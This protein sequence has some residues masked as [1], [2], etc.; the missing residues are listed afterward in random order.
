MLERYP[1]FRE[2]MEKSFDPFEVAMRLALAG[3]VI[4]FGSKYQLDAL[5]ALNN[6]S[7]AKLAV[8]DSKHLRHDLK[9]ATTLLYIGDNCGEIVLDRLFL[10]NINLP[11]MYYAVR[12]GPIINDVT[13]DD[14]EMVGMNRIAKVTS[15]GDDAPGVVW[16]ST[17]KEFKQIFSQADVIIAKGQGNL[18]GLIDIPKNIYFLLVTKCELIGERLGT[19]PDGFVV[20]RGLSIQRNFREHKTYQLDLAHVG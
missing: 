17:S 15:T 2:V 7:R 13:I 3:N 6:G 10:E 4:D 20:K 12:G 16:E 18:E 14:A 1:E 19:H 9:N 5:E 8:D 11:I